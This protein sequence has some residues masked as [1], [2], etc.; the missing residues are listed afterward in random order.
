MVDKFRS[1]C[2]SHNVIRCACE[3][4]GE[5]ARQENRCLAN[6]EIRRPFLGFIHAARQR[7]IFLRRKVGVESGAKIR[8]HGAIAA[9]LYQKLPFPHYLLAVEPDV[10]I[11][12][13][14]VDVRFG[15]PVCARVFGVRM[16]KCNVDSGNLFV[17]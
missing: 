4:V 16:T 13:D 6:P 12:A 9:A 7:G 1:I 5:V 11:A 10:E 3:L 2:R 17:L 14:A 15:N 8:I